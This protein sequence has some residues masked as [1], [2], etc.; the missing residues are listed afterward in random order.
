MGQHPDHPT[1]DLLLACIVIGPLLK[2]TAR[3]VGLTAVECAA[4]AQAVVAQLRAQP[5]A[6]SV[7]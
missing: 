4:L 3:G 7:P 2:A 5:A 6:G 1:T